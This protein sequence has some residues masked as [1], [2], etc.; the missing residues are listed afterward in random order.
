VFKKLAP[1]LELS[2]ATAVAGSSVVV[3]KLITNG[4]PV[5]LSQSLSLA[6]AL[7]VLF[8]VAYR[9]EG[10]IPRIDKKDLLYIFLQSLTGMF[11]FRIF[12]LYGLKYTTAV[13]SGI[14][15]SSTPA[16][17]ALLSF[18]FL[19]ERFGI[20]KG[21]GIITTLSGILMINLL[22][23]EL[24]GD[25][26]AGSVFGN[27]LVMLAV[28][29]EA[30]L[31]IFRKLNSNNVSSVTGTALVTLFSF[32]MFLPVSIFDAVRLDF[33]AVTPL[34][35]VSILYYGVVVTALAYILWFNGVSKVPASTAAAY[36]GFMPVSAV[37]LSCLILKEPLTL[38]HFSGILL[39]ILGIIFISVIKSNGRR[40]ASQR[41]EM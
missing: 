39:V 30:L 29:G 14:I 25:K 5:F 15:T 21:I 22:G 34:Q 24:P 10:G 6:I 17:T 12:M 32:L 41:N 40:S 3:G 35:W 36:T 38:I 28:T 26:G 1:Y 37:V 31:T 18:L 20:I 9:L 7:A 11:L 8:P 23:G 27:I 4:F 13:D 16:V 33:S 2:S 19:R